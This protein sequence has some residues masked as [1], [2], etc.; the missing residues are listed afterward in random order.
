[1]RPT[2]DVIENLIYSLVSH[3][4]DLND[5]FV[6]VFAY[7]YRVA[8][9]TSHLRHADLVYSRTGVAR[10]GTTSASYDATRRS[11]WVIPKNGGD[12]LP[13]LPARYGVFLARRANA[14]AAGTVQRGPSTATE[15]FVFP[16]HK[17][18]I[19]RECLKGQTLQV[20]F[21]KFHRN[22]KLRMTHRLPVSDGGLPVPSGFDI[23]QPPYVRDSSNGGNLASLQAVGASTLVV[24]KPGTTLVRTVSQKNTAANVDQLVHFI[25]P[26]TRTVRVRE[27]RFVDSTLEIPAFGPDRLSLGYV[28]IRHEIDPAGP[29]VPGPPAAPRR[30]GTEPAPGT[31]GRRA[32]LRGT[33]GTVLTFPP[34]CRPEP[35]WNPTPE[36][37]PTL[38]HEQAGSASLRLSRVKQTT[39][40]YLTQHHLSPICS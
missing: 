37:T 20:D 25:V 8:S 27:T 36:P 3:R 38:L 17:L 6:A 10:V 19:G 39:A 40:V 16:V 1:M 11:F 14:G 31:R 5:T 24:P 4:T 7:Q 22:E 33:G 30:R 18:F 2:L 29:V 28:N 26:G 34:A 23:S 21:L 12:D 13:V 35:E 9:R 15:K 32:D